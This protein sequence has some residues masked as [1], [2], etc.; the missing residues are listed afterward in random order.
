MDRLALQVAWSAL[1]PTRFLAVS[2]TTAALD[3]PDGRYQVTLTLGDLGAYGHDDQGVY[4][5]GQP[6]DSVTTEPGE[7]VTV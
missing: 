6:V 7:T 2:D 5:Q 3:L 1:G 4:L